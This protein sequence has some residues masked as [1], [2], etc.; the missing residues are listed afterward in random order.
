MHNAA[1]VQEFIN[2]DIIQV[3]DIV[4]NDMKIKSAH[5]M[6]LDGTM[7]MA[8]LGLVNA[9]PTQWKRLLREEGGF[10]PNSDCLVKIK[11]DGINILQVSF[12]QIY[13]ELIYLKHD[14]SASCLKYSETF[15]IN[16]NDWL[17]YF[18]IPH[19]SGV[20]N[21]VKEAQYKILHSYVA[22]NMLLYKMKV[23]PS[24]RCNFCFLY[25]Q[26]LNHLIFECM[27]VKNVWFKIKGWL[28]EV[29][30]IH[31]DFSLKDVLLG[32]LKESQFVN[33]I[34]LHG[35]Y[36]ILKCKYQDKT[37]NIDNFIDY[38]ILNRQL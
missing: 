33:K 22:T 7:F 18:M 37:P 9:I 14:R 2:K 21:K 36:Y 30:D 6:N 13:E 25:R 34:I 27:V 10:V 29:F 31:V 17:Q 8:Y 19:A 3:K 26:D 28:L 32:S 35:K 15:E 24:S 1:Q 12:R 11:N 20:S 5:E 23:N 16:E 38:L 4:Q